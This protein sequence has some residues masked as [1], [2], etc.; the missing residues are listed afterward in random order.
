MQD[1]VSRYG[2]KGALPPAGGANRDPTVQALVRAT[3]ILDAFRDQPTLG[4]SELARRLGLHKSTIHR[5]LATL[6]HTGYVVQ[7]PETE[8]Y[9]LG[10]KILE[11]ACSL[12]PH[13]DI[14]GRALPVMQQ[15]TQETGKTVHLGVLDDLEVVC[16]QSIVSG[17]PWAIADMARRRLAPHVSS[18]GKVLLAY[19]D[20]ALIDRFIGERGLPRYTERTICSPDAFRHHMDLVRRQGYA[21]SDEEEEI[22][23]RCVAAPVWDRLGD[24][25]AALSVAAPSPQLQGPTLEYT[26]HRT[27]LAARQVTTALEEKRHVARGT[28]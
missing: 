6:E 25:I 28:R 1:A 14:R 9:S 20:A 16:L 3:A 23:I 4:V 21:L 12:P 10:F 8:R 18:M 13:R 5:L 11:L 19:Q 24:V 22:G 2:T 27:I 17:R 7:D 26:V 15:L